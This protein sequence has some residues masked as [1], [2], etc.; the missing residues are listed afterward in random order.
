M[1]PEVKTAILRYSLCSGPEKQAA[2]ARALDVIL[3]WIQTSGP[4]V[5]QQ[6][7][8]LIKMLRGTG[9]SPDFI[10]RVQVAFAQ[11]R[12]LLA[13]AQQ[14]APRV[15]VAT[16]WQQLMMVLR[17]VL[18]N[19]AGGV[20][21]IG[22]WIVNGGGSAIR[23]VAATLAGCAALVGEA[24]WALIQAAVAAVGGWGVVLTALVGLLICLLIHQIWISNRKPYQI[25][26]PLLKQLSTPGLEPGLGLPRVQ[27]GRLG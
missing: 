16:L 5:L 22:R 2:A 10:K 20:S 13:A 19:L 3:K 8:E 1:P 14:L 4:E 25:E 21:N 17:Q 11:L 18:G 26:D 12:Q 7:A 24:T 6:E 9:F 15:P 23:I 27:P